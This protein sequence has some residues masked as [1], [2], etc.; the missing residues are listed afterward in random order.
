MTHLFSLPKG[1][2][3]C[4][5]L[6][7]GSMIGST[8][9]NSEE[10]IVDNG[11]SNEDVLADKQNLMIDFASI[12]SKATYQNPNLRKFLKDES[13]KQFDRNYDVLYALSKDTEIGGTTLREILVSH[14]SEEFMLKVEQAAPMLNI[15]IPE[16]FMFN[17]FPESMDVTDSEIPVAIDRQLYV[18]GEMVYSLEKGEVPG[19]HVFVVSENDRVE[20]VTDSRSNN[21]IIRF[22]SPYYDGSKFTSSESGSRL[23][24]VPS[25]V[26]GERAIQAFNHFYSYD[27]G[28]RSMALQRD[29]IYY[30][31]TPDNNTGN[32]NRTVSEYL[33][34]LEVDPKAYFQITDSYL[35]SNSDDPEI[36]TEK[37]SRKK[38][39][40][41]EEELIEKFWTD[42]SYD[43]KFNVVS[44]T[45]T[46]PQEIHVLAK[47]HE[48][49][50][51][52]LHRTYRN[53]TK[54][55]HSR[56]TYHIDPDDFTM[57]RYY[58]PRNSQLSFGKWDLSEE[59]TTRYVIVSEGD[60]GATQTISHS[61]ELTKVSTQ[62]VNG[63]VKYGLG[64]DQIKGDGQINT[65]ITNSN[66]TKETRQ[67][68][69]TRTDGDDQLGNVKI[70]FYDPI[71]EY[72]NG[73]GTEYYMRT[74]NTGIIAFGLSAE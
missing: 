47:P 10:P 50:D 61:F 31:I 14:S 2:A 35:G 12:L 32:L 39:D 37:I 58:I 70:Y 74:Y 28:N 36:R 69:L 29:Y 55:R 27:S 68:S 64:L 42:G 51:F 4:Y 66:T 8:S 57:K 46:W 33:S 13:L 63:S 23:S 6:I 1:R 45:S 49:W 48:I 62:K 40:F 44:S 17:V 41:T 43:F 19:F 52:N 34:F 73:F 9:C 72:Q 54:L 7:L 18:N 26:P 11:I 21:P 53:P 16:I 65:E 5:T 38:R 3:L 71:I 59:G 25:N 24:C 67:V 20:S 60:T 30:G 56:Y 22:K 15:R